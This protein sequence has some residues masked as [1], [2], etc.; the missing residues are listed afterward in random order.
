MLFLYN[1]N[2][3]KKINILHFLFENIKDKN[4]TFPCWAALYII[5]LLCARERNSYSLL[6]KGHHIIVLSGLS[7]S[8]RHHK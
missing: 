4:S 1:N 6:K 5:C 7:W 8:G 3:T 2:N